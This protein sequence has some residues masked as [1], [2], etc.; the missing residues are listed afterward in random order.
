MQVIGCQLS[1]REPPCGDYYLCPRRIFASPCPQSCHSNLREPQVAIHGWTSPSAPSIACTSRFGGKR[2]RSDV[3]F[4]LAIVPSATD[5]EHLLLIEL[6][7]LWFL[8]PRLASKSQNLPVIPSVMEHRVEI[9]ASVRCVWE[10]RHTSIRR[11]AVSVAL[12]Q[13]RLCP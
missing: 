6:L 7:L 10:T 5:A 8:A 11:L 1:C 9:R 2:S 3:C 4:L 13:G 12:G